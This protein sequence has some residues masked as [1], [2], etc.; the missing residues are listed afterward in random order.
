MT[1]NNNDFAYCGHMRQGIT[2]TVCGSGA[3][4]A[5]GSSVINMRNPSFSDMEQGLER[6]FGQSTECVIEEEE[7][8][9]AI[10]IG[11]IAI[12]IAVIG[13]IALIFYTFYRKSKNTGYQSLNDQTVN[14]K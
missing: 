6:T 14:L 8:K 7:S 4:L 10:I 11:G 2:F 13:G 3:G 5:D 9:T 12:G 1:F